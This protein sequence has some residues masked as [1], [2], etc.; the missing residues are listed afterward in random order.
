MEE[1]IKI[2][3]ELRKELGLYAN[4]KQV[5]Q[6]IALEHLIKAYKEK[7]EENKKLKTEKISYLKELEDRENKMWQLKSQIQDLENECVSLHELIDE[8]M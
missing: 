1:D 3:E 4:E 8:E 7:E 2:L 6:G 5:K